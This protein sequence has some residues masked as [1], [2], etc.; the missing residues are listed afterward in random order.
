MVV[1]VLRADRR[2]AKLRLLLWIL[3]QS[4]YHLLRCINIVAFFWILHVTK[5]MYFAALI[6]S[7]FC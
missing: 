2:E 5:F 4:T 6:F 7:V 1:L 3:L